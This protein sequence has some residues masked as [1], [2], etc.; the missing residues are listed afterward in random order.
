ME[1]WLQKLGAITGVWDWW[2]RQINTLSAET[3]NDEAVVRDVHGKDLKAR[4]IRYH[5]P[6]ILEESKS[7]S[8]QGSLW[9][10]TWWR[11]I[12]YWSDS[13]LAKWSSQ[14]VTLAEQYTA[15]FLTDTELVLSQQTHNLKEQRMKKYDSKVAF[16]QPSPH[17][18]Y[19]NMCTMPN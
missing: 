7:L 6:P 5:A 12:Y 14:N 19:V 1:K 17:P 16:A 11:F 9:Q 3:R 13:S 8:N 2:C 15:C 10:N 18:T 4:E